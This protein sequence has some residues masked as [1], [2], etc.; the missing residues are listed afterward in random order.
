MYL[1]Y[2]CCWCY[3]EIS[4]EIPIEIPIEILIEIP[5]EG[6]KKLGGISSSIS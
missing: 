6:G 2:G 3:I 4:I 5:K 1:V